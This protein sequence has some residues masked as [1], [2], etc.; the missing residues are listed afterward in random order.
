MA[1][2]DD[3][4]DTVVN[5]FFILPFDYYGFALNRLIVI[6]LDGVQQHQGWINENK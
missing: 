5:R 3:D 1:G 6:E 2:G 4:D